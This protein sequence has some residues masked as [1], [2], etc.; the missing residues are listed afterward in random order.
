MHQ[1]YLHTCPRTT[2]HGELFYVK[3]HTLL[4]SSSSC[5]VCA[6]HLNTQAHFDLHPADPDLIAMP[7]FDSF[8]KLP[9]RP[10]IGECCGVGVH[11]TL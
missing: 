11:G 1:L 3:F 2:M 10:E 6:T 8:V 5:M 7:D 9:W 4:T